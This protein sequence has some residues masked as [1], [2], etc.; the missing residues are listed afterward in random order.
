MAV[1]T[2]RVDV[3]QLKKLWVGAGVKREVMMMILATC[4]FDD[5]FIDDITGGLWSLRKK[6]IG[7]KLKRAN[8][9]KIE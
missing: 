6:I 7:K 8:G 2:L 4:G 5:A 1:I 3:E 9:W